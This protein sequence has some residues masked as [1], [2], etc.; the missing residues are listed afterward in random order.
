MSSEIA[1]CLAVV[2]L[3]IAILALIAALDA[4]EFWRSLLEDYR[5][6][7]RSETRDEWATRDPLRGRPRV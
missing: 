1:F 4:R 2:A 6:S 5:A 3:T 7:K